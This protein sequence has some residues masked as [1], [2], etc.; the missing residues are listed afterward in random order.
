MPSSNS[1]PPKKKE[2]CLPQRTRPLGA[3]ALV[4]LFL[5]RFSR[6]WHNLKRLCADKAEARRSARVCSAMRVGCAASAE[7]QKRPTP[8]LNQMVAQPEETGSVRGSGCSSRSGGHESVAGLA[9]GE[10]KRVWGLVQEGMPAESFAT[11]GGAPL[12]RVLTRPPWRKRL[13]RRSRVLAGSC[14]E[15]AR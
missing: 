13:V 9:S 11:R 12:S 7:Q 6:C 15:Q 10:P 4:V 3:A 2:S 1:A 5:L 8:S 14:A